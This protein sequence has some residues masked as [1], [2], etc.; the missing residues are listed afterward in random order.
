MMNAAP[1]FLHPKDL[2]GHVGVLPGM[3]VVDLGMGSGHFVMAA[4][5]LVTSTGTVYAVDVH[6]TA[7]SHL[8]ARLTVEGRSN[9]VPVWGDIEQSDALGID[10]ATCDVAILAGVVYQLKNPKLGFKTAHDL[11]RP[12]GILLLVDWRKAQTSI[13]PPIQKRIDIHEYQDVLSQLG[14]QLREAPVVD[15][16]HDVLVLTKS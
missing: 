16:Q 13:G 10:F 1:S 4:S 12:G 14:F 2:L 5:E 8:N 11:L 6:P 15:N 7:L 3:N 9:V